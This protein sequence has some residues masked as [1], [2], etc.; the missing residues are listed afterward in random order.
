MSHILI[1]PVYVDDQILC[2][3]DCLSLWLRSLPMQSYVGKAWFIDTA[4]F[5]LLMMCQMRYAAK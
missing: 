3:S 1:S 5:G 2:D 4:L